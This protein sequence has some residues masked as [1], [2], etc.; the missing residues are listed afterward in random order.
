MW[1]NL[2]TRQNYVHEALR[3]RRRNSAEA[4]RVRQYVAC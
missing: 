2:A 1:E 4:M 3:N